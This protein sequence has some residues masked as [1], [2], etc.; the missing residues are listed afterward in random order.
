M[1]KNHD[2]ENEVRVLFFKKHL[3]KEGLTYAEALEE[4]L[5]FGWIDG[6]LNRIDG[7]K[8]VIRFSPRRQNSAWSEINKVKVER[9]LKEGALQEVFSC[10]MQFS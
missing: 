10:L 4:A 7:E 8:H 1:E 3:Q 2:T 5:C 6:V 9:L